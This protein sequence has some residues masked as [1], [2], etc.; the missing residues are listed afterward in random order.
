MPDWLF[1]L[2]SLKVH[3][4]TVAH[5]G[6]LLLLASCLW[7]LAA[8]AQPV[9]P[10]TNTGVPYWLKNKAPITI[11]GSVVSTNIGSLRVLIIVRVPQYAMDCNI[12]GIIQ[13]RISGY[14][15]VPTYY[16]I[17]GYPSAVRPVDIGAEVRICGVEAVA[18]GGDKILYYTSEGRPPRREDRER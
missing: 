13:T 14:K 17:K 8:G 3:E 10:S 18:P 5:M 4:T 12:E 6:R 15:E 2:T 7:A 1:T 11:E 9:S 16:T